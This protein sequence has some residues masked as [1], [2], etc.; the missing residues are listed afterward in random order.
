MDPDTVIAQIEDIEIQGATNVARAGIELLQE[1]AAE[2]AS[3]DDLDAVA[4]RLRD[5][6]PTEPLLFN[7]IRRARESGDYGAVLDHIDGAQDAIQD[8]ARD[9]VSDGDVVY[10]HC[11][12]STVTGV[13]REAARDREF[14][15]RVTETRPLYQGRITAEELAGAD[16]PVELYVDSGGRL[17]LKDADVMLIGAD[18]ITAAGKVVNK[19]GSEL[20]AE[21]AAERNVPVHVLTDSWK[22]DPRSE[23]GFDESLE[24]RAADEVWPDAP[25]GVEVVNYAFERVAPGLVDAIVTELG[26]HEPGAFRDAFA[27]AYPDIHGSGAP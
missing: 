16:I 12:S 7:S 8:A 22:Y 15:V 24:R 27:S 11:H 2:G 25:D 6:R 18:A 5:A 4:A 20:F 19:I 17:A 21:V 9:L 10:T 1:M 3:E 13:L 14:T 23:F 26:V